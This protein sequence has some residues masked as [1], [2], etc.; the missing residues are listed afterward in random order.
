[1]KTNQF[2]DSNKTVHL[3][4]KIFNI[5]TFPTQ[6]SGVRVRVTGVGGGKQSVEI[7]R[8]SVIE[9]H[10]EALSETNSSI[11]ASS[12]RRCQEK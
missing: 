4:A 5:C 2:S 6:L 7:S 8:E 10:A 9:N 3:K 12:E 11:M 1:M